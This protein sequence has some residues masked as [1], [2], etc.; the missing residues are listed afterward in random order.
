MKILYD[1]Q[2]FSV[3]KFGGISRYFAQ[4]ISHLAEDNQINIGIKYSNNE[5]LNNLQLIPE[6]EK[7]VYPFNKF[8]S[9]INFR[10]KHT[11]FNQLNRFFLHKNSDPYIFNKNLSIALLKNQDFDIFHPT[12]YDDYFLEYIGN[13]PF[14]LTIHDMI[15]ELY[16][17][18]LN[19]IRLSRRKAFLANKASHIIAV[20]ENTKKDIIDIFGIPKEK[21]SVVYHANSLQFFGD[22]KVIEQYDYLLFVGERGG[23]KNFLFFVR[24]LQPILRDRPWLNVICTGKIFSKTEADLLHELG[25]EQHFIAKNVSDKELITL[26]YSAKVLVFPSY[27]EGFG[28][29]IL[30]AFNVGCPVVLS[31]ASCFKEIAE[32]CALYFNPKSINDIRDAIETI[33]EN[34]DLKNKLI[35]KG[36]DREKYFT[37]EKSA[38]QTFDIYN[39]IIK[40]YVHS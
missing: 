10:G 8:L 39:N 15:H 37:W 29:P 13:K 1:H 38:N 4:I 31:N 24:A 7:L 20:S 11:L 21:I 18:I 26:Y 25:V 33:L 17:E 12:Y 9:K 2:I 36:F 5:Y 3:Q 35:Q 19:D 14:I 27:Y 30:E 22:D 32:D 28:I 40:G 34:E 6:I 23:Y 16:P